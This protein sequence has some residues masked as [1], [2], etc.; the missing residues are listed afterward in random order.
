MKPLTHRVATC[1]AL[2]LIAGLAVLRAD[3][4]T[5]MGTQE[6]EAK[7]ESV[8]AIVTGSIPWVG[9]Q[10][11]KKAPPA[12][13]TAMVQKA[14]AWAKL[15]LQSPAFKSSYDMARSNLKPEAPK[16]TGTWAEQLK[17]QREEFD[18]SAAEMRKNAAG[19]SK[20]IRD[21][22]ENTIKQMQTQLDAQAKDPEMMKTMDNAMA[23]SRVA[24]QEKYKQDMARFD[25]E[26]PASAQ[27]AIAQRLHHFLDVA[28]SVD[29]N[30][31]LV[32]SGSTMKFANPAYEQK[33]T[34]WKLCFRAG[35][36][37]VEAAKALAT[38]WL[39]EIGG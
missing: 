31:K 14:V 1:L 17:K 21:M 32:Q 19:Q 34:E 23:Q 30:A 16:A 24:A 27:M 33:P 38:A 18:K 4:W 28:N 29:F 5:D 13:R 10:V 20:E 37:P 22:I 11:F 6:S 39:K 2:V 25:Q 36:E 7:N 35:R 26:H 3:V 9:A 8:R 12:M 15:Y